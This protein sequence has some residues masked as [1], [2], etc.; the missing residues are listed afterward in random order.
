MK[1]KTVKTKNKNNI[2]NTSKAKPEV[3][4][5]AKYILYCRLSKT[6]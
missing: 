3:I 6:T 2:A 1:K 4:Y 5:N